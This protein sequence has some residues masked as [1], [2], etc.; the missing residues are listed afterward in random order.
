MPRIYEKKNKRS[1]VS[2]LRNQIQSR[3]K[4][5]SK[6][7]KLGQELLPKKSRLKK[8]ELMLKGNANLAGKHSRSFR[9]NNSRENDMKSSF[10]KSNESFYHKK[11]NQSLVGKHSRAKKADPD[12][13]SL[14]KKLQ[15][16]LRAPKKQSHL[17]FI[18]YKRLDR[19]VENE[20]ENVKC[21]SNDSWSNDASQ[22]L[23]NTR[24]AKER[25][26]SQEHTRHYG[27]PPRGMKRSTKGKL[28]K[29]CINAKTTLHN[30]ALRLKSPNARSEN[31]PTGQLGDSE[32][33]RRERSKFLTLKQKTH[34]QSPESKRI[35]DELKL[36]YHKKKQTAHCRS[37]NTSQKQIV[38]R[39]PVPLELPV[40]AESKM[41]DSRLEGV[42]QAGFARP[43]KM[44]NSLAVTKNSKAEPTAFKNYSMFQETGTHHK[45]SANLNTKRAEKGEVLSNLYQPQAPVRQY[46]PHQADPK[47]RPSPMDRSREKVRESMK[48]SADPKFKR[49]NNLKHSKKH[50]ADND[51]SSGLSFVDLFNQKAR[52]FQKY[53][54][55]INP[56]V[57]KY[58]VKRIEHAE[59]RKA[60]LKDHQHQKANY[61]KIIRNFNEKRPQKPRRTTQLNHRASEAKFVKKSKPHK[62]KMN[63]HNEMMSHKVVGHEPVHSFNQ[64]MVLRQVDTSVNNHADVTAQGVHS[65]E[66]EAPVKPRVHHKKYKISLQKE[67]KA[68]GHSQKEILLPRD[69]RHFN[70]KVRSGE[71]FDKREH[72]R[73]LKESLR[74]PKKGVFQAVTEKFR[75]LEQGFQ[76]KMNL[77]KTQLFNKRTL[78]R[79]N[80]ISNPISCVKKVPGL[81]HTKSKKKLNNP[82]LKMLV[83]KMKHSFLNKQKFEKDLDKKLTRTNK[84]DS[85]TGLNSHDQSNKSRNQSEAQNAEAPKTLTKVKSK[86]KLDRMLKNRNFAH[87]A[88]NKINLSSQFKVFKKSVGKNNFNKERELEEDKRKYLANFRM[89][90]FL[91][92][93]SYAEVH[94]AY[95]KRTL[96]SQ[97]HARRHQDVRA[98]QAPRRNP[99]REPGERAEDPGPARPQEHHQALRPHPRRAHGVPRDGERPQAD[100]QRLRQELPPP[101]HRRVR[102]QGHLQ[103]GRRGRGLPA[104]G[105]HRAPRPQNA[106]CARRREVPRQAHRLRLRQL[107]QQAQEI[108]RVLRDLLVHVARAGLPSALRR[109]GHRRVVAGRAALHHAHGGLPLQR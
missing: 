19:V 66:L 40:L 86:L 47:W 106:E 17:Q 44:A 15:P 98:L 55:T 45:H 58:I 56:R 34:H 25:S 68:S 36:L 100:A 43:G 95:D 77:K 31:K 23:G 39:V 13:L 88:K 63:S 91:G 72:Q 109:Q 10:H 67:A 9:R 81:R 101:P 7:R 12:T 64:D 97:R 46:I 102:G 49:K 51:R 42:D 75:D 54:N 83:G 29:M 1:L 80:I 61:E 79:D 26:M 2:G 48:R 33:P 104:R 18:D 103:P 73:G 93:G 96:T 27:S 60:V 59:L 20:D 94:M 30:D 87:K 52:Q 28:L 85:R 69:F 21:G 32:G 70:H 53:Q 99:L 37:L 5:V 108:R 92:K 82:E 90:Q 3:K 16:S 24:R 6:T 38:S 78:W 4:Q 84:K 41:I 71:G 89:I 105:R 74:G 35:S 65:G 22:S 62:P 76:H 8:S 14:D 11:K 57:K 107:L 50:D